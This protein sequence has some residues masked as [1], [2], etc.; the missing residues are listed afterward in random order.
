MF[1][2]QAEKLNLDFSIEHHGESFS[3]VN[4]PK[5]TPGHPTKSHAVLINDS[6][7]KKIVRF[8]QQGVKGSPK[9]EGESESYAK[10]RKAFK[11]R[12]A[13]NIAKGKTSAAFWA[14]KH[15]W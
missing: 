3:G 14:D 8:G 13:K 2:G 11:S 7:K 15:K 4:K 9:K 5:R 10:R 12:H 1:I 6:G